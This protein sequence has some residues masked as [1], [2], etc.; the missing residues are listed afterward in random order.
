MTK[1]DFLFDQTLAHLVGTICY[2]ALS[3]RE[4]QA[5]AVSHMEQAIVQYVNPQTLSEWMYKQDT[6]PH[7]CNNYR[8]FPTTACDPPKGL[9]TGD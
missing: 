6:L 8:D 9:W 3:S 4:S 1:N 7:Y 2:S 5:L